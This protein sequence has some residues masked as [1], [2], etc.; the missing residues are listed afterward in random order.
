MKNQ[1]FAFANSRSGLEGTDL[2]HVLETMEPR[3]R[4]LAGASIL[5]TGAT[6]WFGVWL[7]DVLCA[8]D[9]TLRLGIRIVAVSRDPRHFAARYPGFGADPRIEWIQSDV[10]QLA[11]HGDGFTY[12]IHAATDTS[13]RP[14]AASPLRLFETIVDGTRCAIAAAGATCKGFLLLSSGAIYGLGALNSTHFAEG[15]PGGPKAFSGKS[16]Y[17]EGKRAAE[18]LAIIAA[19]NGVPVR[20]ARCFAFVGPHM[21]F[22]RHFAIG[23]FIA[24]AVDGRRILVKSDGRPLRSYLYMSDLLRALIAIL[25]DGVAG[26]P[27]NVGS[28]IAITIEE[29]AHRVNRVVGGNGVQIEGAAS[30]PLDRYVPNTTRLRSELG[31]AQEVPLDAAIARTAKW[32]R[33]EQIRSMRS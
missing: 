26:R 14:G 6:G 3:L 32:R 2:R 5:I 21:P 12:V 27:Y 11:P 1:H 8:A 13:V 24:D 33:A 19:G 30:D 25:V 20:I 4:Q 18:Q 22:D 9:D 15:D 10:R 29:L 28:D 16:A 23:N 31:F 7:L 17:A